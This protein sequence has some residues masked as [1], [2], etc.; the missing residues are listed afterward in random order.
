[1]K[2]L[3][4]I[5]SL[6]T[7]GAEKLMVD[8]LPRMKDQGHQIELCTFDNTI[9]PFRLALE[10]SG[11]TIH[12]FHNGVQDVYNP[13]NIIRL[14]KLIKNRDFDIIH[15]HNTAPQLFTA[16][17]CLGLNV[18]LIT[19]EHNTTNRRRN[20][21]LFK[22]LDSWMYNKYSNI[23]CISKQAEINLKSYLPNIKGVCTIF[24][25]IDYSKYANANIA[26]DVRAISNKVITMVAAFRP[27]KDQIT[28]IKAMQ[29]L[30]PEFHLCLVGSGEKQREEIFRQLIEKLHLNKR[31]H[32]LG[33]RTDIPNV[34][35]ASDYVVMSSHYEGLSLSNLE[36]MASGKPFIA[37]DVDGLHEIVKDCG[38]LVKHEDPK[39]LSKAI[40]AL[41]NDDEYKANII[42][43][44][45]AKAKKYDISI[46]T[47]KYINVYKNILNK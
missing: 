12:S 46:M 16:I 32:L 2:I 30:S 20:N 34:L 41:D 44:C 43:K 36:G 17:A 38:V 11:I 28:L 5:T 22:I 3:H 27:Q 21:I 10:E 31:V 23:I 14:R 45:Q 25:G 19:T 42:E 33:M 47:E 24:N 4:I 9:T 37:S 1:M 8:L 40:I 18:P 13:L 15:T 35:A 29:F 26:T 6:L 39:D 7:G